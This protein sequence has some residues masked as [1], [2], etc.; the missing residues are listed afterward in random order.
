[1]SVIQE[2]ANPF[3]LSKPAKTLSGKRKTKFF[4]SPISPF[5]KTRKIKILST[6][7][8]FSWNKSQTNSENNGKLKLTVYSNR[9]PQADKFL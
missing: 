8:P 6:N 5:S 9:M 7:T 1:M 4:I 2:G 3:Q